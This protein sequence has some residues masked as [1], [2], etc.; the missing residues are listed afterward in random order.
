MAI[1]LHG[2]HL[3]LGILADVAQRLVEARVER[4]ARLAEPD[5]PGAA[6]R[7][8]ELV[9]DGLEAGVELAVLAGPVDGVEHL[10]D[11]SEGGYVAFSRTSSRSRSTRRL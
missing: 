3:D 10:D 7:A 9:G 2:G 6:D 5:Q 8:L 1:T 4:V 11:R